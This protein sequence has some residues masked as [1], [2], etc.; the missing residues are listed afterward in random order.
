MSP[1]SSPYCPRCGAADCRSAGPRNAFACL[2]CGAQFSVDHG[3][4]LPQVRMHTPASGL[5]RLQSHMRWLFPLLVVLMVLP[6]L[7]PHV[8]QF[9]KSD[10]K[11]YELRQALGRSEGATIVERN[12]QRLLVQLF[13]NREQDQTVYRAVISD[14]VSGKPLA[15]PQRFSMHWA[16]GSGRA[17][18]RFF[19]DGQLYLTLQERGLWRLDPATL[20]FVDLLP[21]LGERFGPQLGA[22]VVGV[23]IQRRGRPDSLEVTSSTGSKYLVYWLLGQIVPAAESSSLYQ[24]A[25]AS[26]SERI[27][28]YRYER[29][30]RPTGEEDRALLVRS[31]W[32]YEPGQP[33]FFDYFDLLP[34]DSQA[35]RGWPH[36]YIAIGGGFSTSAYAV[37][38][39]GLLRIDVVQ[40]AVPRFHADILAENTTRVLLTYTPTPVRQEGRVIQLLDK[41]TGQVVWSRTVDQLPQLGSRE[42]GLYVTGQ[43]VNGGFLLFN[44]L[45]QPA[46]LIGDDGQTVHD[47]SPPAKTA[48]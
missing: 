24:K 35:V 15:E 17:E 41:A 20:R 42:G 32:R 46:S 22:G 11:P 34:T 31:W 25:Q 18:L 23:A 16:S 33:I 14:M 38:D 30:P 9:F 4:G 37:K 36:H 44:D 1:W 2:Q 26:Y 12:G 29:L 13:E 28:Y 5:A 47:F 21:Q 6:W 40:P 8:Q 43:A 3:Q 48:R 19:S 27:P 45:Q 39:R 10:M 7:V